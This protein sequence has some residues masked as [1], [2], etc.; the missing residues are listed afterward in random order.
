M[1]IENSNI[2]MCVVYEHFKSKTP[3]KILKRS[4]TELSQKY[5][6]DCTRK[7]SNKF[8]LN[9]NY[10]CPCLLH[11]GDRFFTTNAKG[12]KIKIRLQRAH[13]GITRSDI[14]DKVLDT[15]PEETNIIFLLD[16]VMLQHKTI[17]LQLACQTCNK[18]LE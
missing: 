9:N 17:K 16:Q 4:L 15:Y 12:Q 1:D 5:T 10:Y 11:E 6:L 2:D 18:K 3:R 13:V 7:M 14:I 8:I